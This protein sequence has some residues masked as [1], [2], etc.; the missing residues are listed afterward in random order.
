MIF[1]LAFALRAVYTFQ[2]RYTPFFQTLGLDAKFYDQWARE[3]AGGTSERGAF[4]MTPLYSYFLAA[5]Y[6]LFGRDLLLV[7]M[8]Q[9]GMGAAT[10]AIVYLLGKEIFDRRVGILAGLITAGYG[11]L[12]FYDCSVLL[13]PL[14]VFLNVLAVFLLVR[15]DTTGRP[16]HYILAGAVLGLA[17]IGRAAAL[18]SAAVAVLWVWLARRESPEGRKKRAKSGGGP[19]TLRAGAL[20]SAVLVAVGIVVVVAPVTVRNFVVERDFVLI[21]SNG[22]LN[23]FIGNGDGATGGY[24]KP[25]GLDIVSDPDGEHIAE[26][27]VGRELKPSEVSGYWYGRARANIR[28]NPGGWVRLM[29]RKVAFVMSSYEMPQLENYY[30][31][32]RYSP[33]LRIP[34]LGFAIIAPLGLLGLGLAFRRRRPRLLA[35][36]TSSYLLSISA[37][38]VVA[39]YR[40]P[41]V[42]F[43]V[44]FASYGVFELVRRARAKEYRLL[45]LPIAV[46]AV[47]LYLVNANHYD[48][49]RETGFAQPHFRLGIIYSE[50]GE[51]DDAIYEYEQAIRLDPDYSKSYLNLGAAF[52]EAGRNEEAKQAFR[53]AIRLDPGYASARINLAMLLE[54]SEEYER[55]LSQVD[56]VLSMEPHN[57]TALKE[58]GVILYRVGDAEGAETWLREA[59]TWDAAG[60]E[61]PEIEFY[62]ALLGGS[63]EAGIP[64]EASAM[65]ARADTL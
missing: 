34:L 14:L 51:I 17:A 29:V 41:V 37:F 32:K 25:E 39:R 52:S 16:A 44:L 6:R 63:G 18:V 64:V 57:P 30:F 61:R 13:T 26:R 5:V 49:N 54:R 31:Q 46:L 45:V 2:V 53:S 12:I 58:R 3:I 48:I 27:D 35:L 50:R 59:L 15:A 23:F 43:L 7:R 8:I 22:G 47:L 38:F 21:T 55:A 24:V 28:R 4:F 1:A 42:P 56:T 11:A 40:L 19:N 9:A 33:L 10:A 20:R 62:L 36:Y 60:E 65:M